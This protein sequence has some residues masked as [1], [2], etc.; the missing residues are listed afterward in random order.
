[1]DQLLVDVGDL[2][3]HVG[4]DVVLLGAQGEL[5]IDADEWARRLDTISYEVVTRLG[6][7][8][9]RHHEGAAS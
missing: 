2:D 4:D 5:V 6:G 3:V 8:L 9:P 7:R 1:M